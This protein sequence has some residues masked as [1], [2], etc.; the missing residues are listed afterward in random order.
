VFGRLDEEMDALD[1]AGAPFAICPGVTAATAA[2]ASAR[3][4]LTRRRRNSSLR[5]LTGHDVDGFAA[6]DWR[7]LAA[8]GAVAAIYM[9]LRAA[10]FLRDQLLAAGADPD[11]PVTAVENASRKDERILSAPLGRLPDALAQAGLGGPAI[12]FLGVEPRADGADA[13]AWARIDDGVM[14]DIAALRAAG[15]FL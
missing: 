14:A 11:T 5:L 7:A 3:V 13:F 9:G 10:A 2:A 1:A 15:D 6:Q 8:P 4:S 12:L